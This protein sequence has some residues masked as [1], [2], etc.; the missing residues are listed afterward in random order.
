MDDLG[1][2]IL[3]QLNPVISS[4]MHGKDVNAL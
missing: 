4:K 2:K 1:G 3:G